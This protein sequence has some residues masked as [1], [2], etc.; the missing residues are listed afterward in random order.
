VTQVLSSGSA[1]HGPIVSYRWDLGDGT[2]SQDAQPQHV[3]ANAGTYNVT[4]TIT[5][6]AGDIGTATEALA[7]GPPR[8]GAGLR[9]ASLSVPGGPGSCRIARGHHGG[10]CTAR[11]IKVRG[12]IGRVSHA[13]ETV[14]LA[15]SGRVHGKRVTVHKRASIVGGGF[16]GA[17]AFP[18]SLHQSGERWTLTVS[19]TGDSHLLAATVTK[20]F[21]L[22]AG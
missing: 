2:I 12:R 14:R 20:S 11:K 4:V 10:T 17:I 22:E 19:Y 16:A 8:T 6:G 7:I 18:R 1:S 15:L 13:G 9:I 3:Y 5:D 21:R